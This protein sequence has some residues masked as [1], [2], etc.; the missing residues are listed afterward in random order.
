MIIIVQFHCS[1]QSKIQCFCYL[2][3]K[4]FSYLLADLERGSLPSVGESILAWDVANLGEVTSRPGGDSLPR[5]GEEATICLASCSHSWVSLLLTL[6]V[7][8]SKS[9]PSSIEFVLIPFRLYVFLSGLGVPKNM[10]FIKSVKSGT[11]L[12]GFLFSAIILCKF[13]E[14]PLLSFDRFLL[15]LLSIVRFKCVEAQ[16]RRIRMEMQEILRWR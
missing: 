11:G 5:P 10:S 1:D 3:K 6:L 15:N 12:A 2:K 14:D 16:S 7:L 9:S 13:F 8:E 4:S